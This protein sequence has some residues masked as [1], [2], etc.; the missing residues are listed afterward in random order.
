MLTLPIFVFLSAVL[1]HNAAPVIR[2][3]QTAG[4]CYK[5]GYLGHHPFAAFSPTI[6]L[7][8]PFT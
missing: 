1:L 4:D 7:K 8:S 3:Q 6:Q 5:L 2:R